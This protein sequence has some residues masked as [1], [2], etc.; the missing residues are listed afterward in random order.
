MPA[1]DRLSPESA[2]AEKS[3]DSAASASDQRNTPSSEA[4]VTA[5]RTPSAYFATKTAVRAKREAGW[6]NFS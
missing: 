6:S 3:A 2:S 4:P 5:T 1:P